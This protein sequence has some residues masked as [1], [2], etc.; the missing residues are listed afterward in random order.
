MLAVPLA[1]VQANPSVWL[2]TVG[3]PV[4][5]HLLVLEAQLLDQQQNPIRGRVFVITAVDPG[6][7]NRMR[8]SGM[9]VRKNFFTATAPNR[10]PN[11]Q[12][13]GLLHVAEKKNGIVSHLPVV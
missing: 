10:A 13:Q 3:G 8:C 5:R 6:N 4:Q 9:L 12:A 7:P 1:I 2:N 11:W